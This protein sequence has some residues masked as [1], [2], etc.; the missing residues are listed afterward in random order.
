MNNKFISVIITC[1]IK[2]V[3]FLA[4]TVLPKQ[5]FHMLRI[6]FGALL[7][8][9][10]KELQFLIIKN[11]FAL[12]THNISDNTVHTSAGLNLS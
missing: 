7:E 2:I 8:A 6:L 11:T 12:N 4:L 3:H 1:N 10:K 9:Y 5:I